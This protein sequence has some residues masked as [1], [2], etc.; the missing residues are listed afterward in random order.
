[1]NQDNASQGVKIFFAV[2]CEEVFFRYLWVKEKSKL[3]GERSEWIRLGEKTFFAT[4]LNTELL[5]LDKG[6][7]SLNSTGHNSVISSGFKK[8]F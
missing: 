4:F 2:L 5:P 8:T 3:R 7:E 6:D 1:M